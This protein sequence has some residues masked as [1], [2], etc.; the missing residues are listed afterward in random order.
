MAMKR[1]YRA[2]LIGAALAGLWGTAA[3]AGSGDCYKQQG[4]GGSG[5]VGT[6]STSQ[7]SVGSQSLESS[8]QSS[9]IGTESSSGIGGSGSQ[10]GCVSPGTGGSGIESES[11][12]SME[13]QP[14]E[15]Q[16]M[17]SQ[18]SQSQMYGSTTEQNIQPEAIAPV[19]PTARERRMNRWHEAGKDLK[20]YPVAVRVGGGTEGT[21][22]NLN[23]TLRWG[24]QW[25]A[26][27]SAQPLTWMGAELAYNG[28]TH[29]LSNNVAPGPNHAVN[30]ADFVSNGGQ[31][32]VTFNAPTPIVQP[33]ALGGIGFDRW[34]FRGPDTA[35]FRD[36]TAGRV[37]V[38]GGLKANV[39]QL[40][41][42]LRYNYNIL[43]SQQFARPAGSGTG[44]SM[45]LALQ[46]GG[47]F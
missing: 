20:R 21:S 8:S 3:L 37:P 1:G 46:V 41:A 43:F 27:I 6:S 17:G 24:P 10:S 30:G 14:L 26:G 45:D 35:T 9:N 29:E 18:Q 23:N 19:E 33:Y 7:S 32:A 36:D 4:T 34:N 13:Q 28:A 2:A 47:R 22:G 25:N 15:Q 31:A 39:G 40:S 5:N 12:T 42:D 11:Q 16:P 38:G 44:G